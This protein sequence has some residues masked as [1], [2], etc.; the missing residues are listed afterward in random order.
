VLDDIVATVAVRL[1]ADLRPAVLG[2]AIRAAM[3]AALDQWSVG[4]ADELGRLMGEAFEIVA[5][6]GDEPRP[7]V[8]TD[9]SRRPR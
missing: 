8:R 9:R 2:G 4:D 3:V 1:A 7:R 6:T 5:T